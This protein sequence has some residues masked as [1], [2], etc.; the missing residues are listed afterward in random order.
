MSRWPKGAVDYVEVDTG[1]RTPCWIWQKSVNAKGYGFT[2]HPFEFAHRR[3]FERVHGPIPPGLEPD[4]LCRQRS[5]V[6]PDHMEV[7]PHV[8]NVRRASGTKL[9]LDLAIEI[10]RSYIPRVVTKL[11]LAARFNVSHSTVKQILAGTAW[12]E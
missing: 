4:H 1:H 12:K 6:N 3:Y 9:T 8:V 7:V 5:C 2:Q 11:D 10:R